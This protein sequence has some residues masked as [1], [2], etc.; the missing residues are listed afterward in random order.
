MIIRKI[1]PFNGRNKNVI[2]VKQKAGTRKS[3]TPASL[4]AER[5]FANFCGLP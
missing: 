2:S 5:H 4:K 3:Q 1:T